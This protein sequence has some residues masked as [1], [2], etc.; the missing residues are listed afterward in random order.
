M[1]IR[2]FP[3]RNDI[4]RDSAKKTEILRFRAKTRKSMKFCV[5]WKTEVSTYNTY[6]NVI[7]IVKTA[8]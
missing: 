3:R 7:D 5:S 2:C 1:K 4:F 6:Y 8:V